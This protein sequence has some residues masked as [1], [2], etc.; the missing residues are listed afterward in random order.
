VHLRI[1][2][3]PTIGPCHYGIDTPTREELIAHQHTV[4]EIRAIMGADSLG[5]LGLE[6]LRRCGERL[7]HGF[8]DACFSDDYPVENTEGGP[9]PQLSLF[10]PVNSEDI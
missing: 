9:V 3:P 6:G 7:K 2:S 5:Y 1:S 8:C 4:D 10:R